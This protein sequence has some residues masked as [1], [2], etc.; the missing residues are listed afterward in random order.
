MPHSRGLAVMLTWGLSMNLGVPQTL[1]HILDFE[2]L[3][4]QFLQSEI[5]S[6]VAYIAIFPMDLANRLVFAT[7]PWNAP[8]SLGLPWPSM[9]HP[10]Q[11]R[12]HRFTETGAVSLWR[13]FHCSVGGFP[14]Q[15]FWSLGPMTSQNNG[16][17]TWIHQEQIWG[18]YENIWE[19]QSFNYIRF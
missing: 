3:K 2:L 9:A 16:G 19:N 12:I 14:A 11:R 10:W 4:C 18:K 15:R 8:K 1:L 17:L 5:P 13:E 6:C 7:N